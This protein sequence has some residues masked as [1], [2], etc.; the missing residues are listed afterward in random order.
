MMFLVVLIVSSSCLIQTLASPIHEHLEDLSLLRDNIPSETYEILLEKLATLSHDEIETLEK[1]YDDFKDVYQ[2]VVNDMEVNLTLSVVITH[3]YSW[4]E[5]IY[6][7][8]FIMFYRRAIYVI[9]N[10]TYGIMQFN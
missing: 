2:D 10:I 3:F 5:I 9:M 6:L 8:K 7:Q 1:Y 4:S